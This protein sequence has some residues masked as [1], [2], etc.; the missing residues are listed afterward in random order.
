[1]AGWN[2]NRVFRRARLRSPVRTVDLRSLLGARPLHRGL[3]DYAGT[4]EWACHPGTPAADVDKPGSHRRS[5]ELTYLLS[6]RFR[7]LLTAH[8]ARLVTYWQV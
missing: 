5:D 1:M 4:V 3:V 2:A 8:H 6:P 7:E